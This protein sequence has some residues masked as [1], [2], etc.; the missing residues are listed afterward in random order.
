ME[1][2]KHEINELQNILD[3]CRKGPD[4]VEFGDTNDYD[5]FKDIVQRLYYDAWWAP[6]LGTKKEV[7]TGSA[8][9]ENC[10]KSERG[11][12]KAAK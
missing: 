9:L 4:Y 3:R 5:R 7:P 11:A 12:E 2:Y 6:R 8:N 10:T 1:Q